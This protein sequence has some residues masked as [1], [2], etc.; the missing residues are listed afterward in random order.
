MS[1][2][3]PKVILRLGSHAEKEYFEKLAGQLDGIMFGGN[4]LEITPSAT[5]SLLALLKSKRGSKGPM[6]YYLD[7]M[8]YCFGAYIDPTTGR[9]RIDLHALKSTR[10]DRKTKQTFTAV[11]DSYTALAEE[12]GPRFKAATGDGVSCQA[13]DPGKIAT[14]QRNDFCKHVVDYQLNRIAEVI[15]NETPEDDEV[16]KE[17]FNEIGH[18]AAVFAPYFYV[19]ESWASD[20]LKVALDLIARTAALDPPVP[21]HAILCVSSAILS[22][23]DLVEFIVDEIPKTKVA[24]VWFWFDGFDESDS[25]LDRLK[26]FRRLARGLSG[27]VHVFN[28]HGGYY[29]LL[30]AHDGLSGISH[31]IGYGERKPVAQVIGAAAPT[32]RY[33]LPP[34]YKRVGVPDVQRSFYDVGINTPDDFFRMVCDCQICKGVIGKDLSR[35]ASFGEM[36]RAKAESTKSTQTPAAAKMCRFHFLINR[37]KERSSVA[38]MTAADRDRVLQEKAAPWRNL[39]SLL[40]YLGNEGEDGYLEMWRQSFE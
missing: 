31:G 19:H 17:A 40:Q 27:K 20:G 11:K 7:P 38:K 35:F 29:S 1:I 16:I 15:A 26:S 21:T 34:I 5:A 8:S 37:L 25:T 28:L 12:L 2:S 23:T 30:L 13:I 33:Y 10:K 3:P 6:P 9:K 32:V 4:L 36:H 18:P 22:N 39:Y 14:T 24:G